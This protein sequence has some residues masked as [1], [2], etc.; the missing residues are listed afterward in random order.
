MKHKAFILAILLD[1][2]YLHAEPDA[3]LRWMDKIAQEE[4]QAREDTIGKI[5][6]VA[7]A[8]GRKKIVREKIMQSLGG[9]PEYSGPLNARVTGIIHADGFTIEK[10]IYES[11]PGFFV[12]ADLYRPNRPGRY[13]GVL[14]QSGH[15]QEGKAEPQLLAANLALK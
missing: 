12:T 8:E 15:T 14:L 3:L 4:L 1:I 6:T 2:G 11:L 9:L 10:I 7:D 13:P 5:R